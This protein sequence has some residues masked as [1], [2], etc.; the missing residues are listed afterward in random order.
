MKPW[1]GHK[2]GWIYKPPKYTFPGYF[3]STAGKYY[4][5]IQSFAKSP[6]C[7]VGPNGPCYFYSKVGSFTV[8]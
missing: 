2:D 1:R 5:E 8:R 7:T 3:A 4:W 6:P